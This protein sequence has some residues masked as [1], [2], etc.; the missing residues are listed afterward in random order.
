EILNS[1]KQ[2]QTNAELKQYGLLAEN[3]FMINEKQ[4]I[5]V[6]FWYQFN[7]RNIPP[8]MLQT[9]NKSNQKDE[10]YRITSQW[11]RTGEKVTSLVRMALFNE[12]LIYTD[13]ASSIRS[14]SNSQTFIAEAESKI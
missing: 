3:Y 7:D 10:S 6:C 9:I 4:K 2:V 5:N 1:P 12:G 14:V 13:S 11:Q 8:I